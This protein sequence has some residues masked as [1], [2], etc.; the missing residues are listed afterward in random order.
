[1]GT[2]LLYRAGRIVARAAARIYFK[3]LE[4]AGAAHVP[5]SRPV[6][7]AANHPQSITDALVLA[8]AAGRMV[9]Y[10]GH[11]G[12]FHNPI[13][14]WLLR[15]LGVVPIYRKHDVEKAADKNAAMF[16]ACE[17]LLEQGGAIGIFPEGISTPARQLQKLKTGAA[18]IA[19][20]TEAR[21]GWSLGV[22][23]VPTGLDFE[24]RRR[25][26]TRVLIRFG[27]AL[28]AADYRAA[29]QTDPI[30]TVYSLT[31]TLQE[32]LTDLV[33]HIDAPVL[34]TLVR[35]VENIYRDEI[36]RDRKTQ[37]PGQSDYEKRQRVSS[38]IPRAIRFFL[39]RDPEVVAHVARLLRRY[40]R[41]LGRLHLRDEV[42]H[43]ATR[44]P[45]KR[46]AVVSVVLGVLGFPLALY[47]A[48]WN[49]LPYKFTGWLARRTA[50]DA[51]KI[52]YNQITQGAVIYT[53]YYAGLLY[54]VHYATGLLVTLAFTVALPVTGLFARAYTRFVVRRQRAIRFVV[55]QFVHRYQAERIKQQRRLVIAEIDHALDVYLTTREHA[56]PIEPRHDGP[57]DRFAE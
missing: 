40:R 45:S 43:E 8:L 39:A 48:L 46:E 15:N 28:T 36:L 21:N 22:T 18:R 16:A 38:E 23:I 7:L 25:M 12:L 55:F 6:L 4:I 24:S 32:R 9:H 5:V 52:H 27:A 35:D 49:F 2:P 14:A 51:T 56:D 44:P 26:R 13:R 37:I 17:A 47:G 57:A 30:E 19:L 11:G 33:V 31:E 3:K 20:Q 34:E 41:M 42:V 1:M 53:I 29:Y 10:L 54:A 50:K